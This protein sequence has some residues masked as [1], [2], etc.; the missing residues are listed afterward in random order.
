MKNLDKER[1]RGLVREGKLTAGEAT[2]MARALD[3]LG[4]RAVPPRPRATRRHG[5][6]LGELK[7]RFLAG[8]IDGDEYR[9]ATVHAAVRLALVFGAFMVLAMGLVGAVVAFQREGPLAAAI[10]FPVAS[11]VSVPMNVG[12][13]ALFGYLMYRWFL[14]PAATKLAALQ[15]EVD[16][17]AEPLERTRP[18]QC[19]TCGA[20]NKKTW[21]P[22]H[23]VMLHWFLNPG[24][25]VNELFL[26][27]RIPRVSHFCRECGSSFIDCAGCR[28]SVDAMDWSVRSQFGQ[29]RGMHCVRCGGKIPVMRNATALILEAP[30]RLA[31]GLFRSVPREGRPQVP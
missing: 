16:L 6:P 24:L 30:V 1:L 19:P 7:A 11:L 20:E 8:E 10:A 26:G 22:L 25:A 21:T 17:G 31:L 18:G 23:P 13:G 4:H 12:A 27:Q 15:S 2:Q 3:R 28:T 14:Q 5:A 29:W 9:R